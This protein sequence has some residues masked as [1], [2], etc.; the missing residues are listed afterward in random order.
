M[1]LRR[2]QLWTRPVWYRTQEIRRGLLCSLP[3]YD[4][5]NGVVGKT[6]SADV[7]VAGGSRFT[8]PENR[9]SERTIQILTNIEGSLH[10]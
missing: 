1:S 6:V 10:Q 2:C 3:R 8:R 7:L 5:R 4:R 9:N